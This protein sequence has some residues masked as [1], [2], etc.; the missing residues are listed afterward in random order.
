[1]PSKSN[2]ILPLTLQVPPVLELDQTS[3]E[4]TKLR[5]LHFKHPLQ[6]EFSAVG[7]RIF[8]ISF[9]IF[10]I[11]F[12]LSWLTPLIALL[13]KLESEGPV[14]FGQIRHG[15]NSQPFYCWKFRTM[16]L[17]DESDSKQALH[18]D[19][20]ITRI[21]QYLRKFNID[22]IPQFINVLIGQMSVVGPRPHMLHH[23]LVYEKEIKW[24]RDRL[25]VKPGITGLAQVNGSQ[26][27]TP[28]VWHMSRRVHYDLFYIRNWSFIFDLKIIFRTVVNIFYHSPA[29]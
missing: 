25:L 9:S 15:L 12:V 26:G 1:M 10:V 11:V 17:N 18:G 16:Y 6:H 8:D 14:F 28:T 3:L 27:P 13:I 19:I 29:K 24:Y 23:T 2:A 4:Q 20:R 22:E 7:K 21:G 5:Q